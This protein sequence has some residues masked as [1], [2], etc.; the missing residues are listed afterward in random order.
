MR[1]GHNMS[2]IYTDAASY[3]KAMQVWREDNER[4]IVDYM[5]SVSGHGVFSFELFYKFQKLLQWG[6]LVP[7]PWQMGYPATSRNRDAF[8]ANVDALYEAKLADSFD[9]V[10]GA[11]EYIDPL[12]TDFKDA[13]ILRL[14]KKSSR[15]KKFL[16]VLI[17]VVAVIAIAACAIAIASAGTAAGSA[18]AGAS[19]TASATVPAVTTAA[20]TGAVTSTATAAVTNAV[21]GAV[22]ANTATVTATQM[23]LGAK[24][25]ALAKSGVAYAVKAAPKLISSAIADKVVEKTVG[26]KQEEKMQ[27]EQAVMQS[28]MQ[29]AQEKVIEAQIQAEE[30]KAQAEIDA[31]NRETE[32]LNN[33]AAGQSASW[34]TNPLVLTGIAFAAKLFL[35]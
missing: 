11:M 21:T 12:D 27:A 26:K 34:I 32:R 15:F 31:I 28:E 22:V 19:A 6:L 17:I 1:M 4:Q 16:K 8:V 18:A 35:T 7:M 30:I 10:K 13:P 9:N 24:V 2:N 20:T 25:A 14:E 5:N 33:V 3:N 23:T 29:A